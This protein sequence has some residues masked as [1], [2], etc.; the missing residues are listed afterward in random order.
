MK[1]LNT[2]IIYFIFLI[3]L[4][5]DGQVSTVFASL[6]PL[7]VHLVSHII[8]LA[9]LWGS[10][11]L[12][13]FNA[14]LVSVF[15]GICYDVYF[16][17]SLGLASLLFPFS[18]LIFIEFNSTFIRNIWTYLLSILISI[19]SFEMI[20][21]SFFRIFVSI[22]LSVIDFVVFSLLPTLVWNLCCYT[23]FYPIFRKIFI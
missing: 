11:R 12:S 2:I 15:M 8:F 4:L 23:L 3:L 9:F 18:M 1:I 6:L 19:F 21:F 20:I 10:V 17:N 14:L 7:S 22:N 16:L 13:K 5:I